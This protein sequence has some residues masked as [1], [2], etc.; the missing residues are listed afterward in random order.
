MDD[1]HYLDLCKNTTERVSFEPINLLEVFSSTVTIIGQ[2]F[3]VG[4]YF[5]F[6]I[7]GRIMR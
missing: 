2:H 3:G 5:I 6:D 4:L 7:S 1:S